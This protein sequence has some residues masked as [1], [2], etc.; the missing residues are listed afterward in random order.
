MSAALNPITVE[1]ITEQLIAIV[2][3]MRATMIQR[4]IR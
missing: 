1:I 3:E 2:R 4:R